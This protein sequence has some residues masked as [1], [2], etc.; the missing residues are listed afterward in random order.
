MR[1]KLRDEEQEGAIVLLAQEAFRAI[2]DE[3]DAVLILEGDLLAVAIEDGAFE[4]MA[5]VLECVGALSKIHEAAAVLG[6]DESITRLLRREV[7]FSDEIGAVAC[8]VEFAGE[9]G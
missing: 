8:F 3:V 2:G 4:G 6:P 5:G 7:P 1:L 9:G